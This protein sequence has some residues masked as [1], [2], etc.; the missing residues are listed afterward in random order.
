MAT[1]Q[2]LVRSLV[3]LSPTMA[4]YGS[5]GDVERMTPLATLVQLRKGVPTASDS[6]S[7][8]V[9][10]KDPPLD[11]LGAK[12][13][14]LYSAHHAR[15]LRTC[16]NS[17]TGLGHKL[18]MQESGS[19]LAKADPT[20]PA[21]S[22]AAAQQAALAKPRPTATER[23]MSKADIALD[24][25]CDHSW[26]GVLRA[27]TEDYYETGTGYIEVV[28][29]KRTHEIVAIHHRPAS[30]VRLYVDGPGMWHYAIRSAGRVWSGSR[31]FEY[32]LARWG[33]TATV[34]A[35]LLSED[36]GIRLESQ[37]RK[38]Q[39]STG[40]GRNGFY[41]EIIDIVPQSSDSRWYGVPRWLSALPLIDLHRAANQYFGDYYHNHG[42][43]DVIVFF[44]GAELTPEQ[45]KTV[46]EKF[47]QT[48]G[49][50]NHHKSMALNI[51]NPNVKL[52]IE[53]L[54]ADGLDMKAIQE[55]A[56]S[57][58]LAIV[59]AWGV[60]PLLAGIQTPGKLGAN[61][62][63][64]NSL[65]SFQ[66]LEIG[67]DQRIFQQRLGKTLGS[68][69]A[70]LGLTLTDLEFYTTLDEI[71]LGTAQTV[72]GMREPLASAQANGRDLNAGLK[73]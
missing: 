25:L 49:L 15:C 26:A 17:C 6:D 62:E 64:P 18:D 20:K 31:G 47:E 34:G 2:Q 44:S 33:E 7:L 60:P 72:A 58:N 35:A 40:A 53:K 57:I 11:I 4:L 42:V 66:T 13:L 10:P 1:T 12:R 56:E 9:G 59:T 16:V 41:R 68:E 69:E 14:K 67:Q 5:P 71:D 70:K 19:K 21:G 65:Q 22:Q 29:K 61:N 32:H 3:M 24:P 46:E 43:P 50:G 55:N 23:L 37:R 51:A 48:K 27:V 73:K 30:D 52:Q 28:R 38:E 54:A 39:S 45:W 8:L 36:T 63:M